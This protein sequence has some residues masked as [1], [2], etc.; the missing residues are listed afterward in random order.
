MSV[1]EAV[2]EKKEKKARGAETPRAR[3]LRLAVPRVNRAVRALNLV[4]NLNAHGYESTP[5]DREKIIDKIFN[6]VHETKRR[7]EGKK[8]KE[9]FAL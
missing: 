1:M 6:T 9:K 4:G 3:F 2:A 7:L 8:T 5:E